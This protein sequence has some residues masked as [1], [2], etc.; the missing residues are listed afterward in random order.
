[1]PKHGHKKKARRFARVKRPTNYLVASVKGGKI[2]VVGKSPTMR[3]AKKTA[4]RHKG[5]GLA[6]IQVGAIY[7]TKESGA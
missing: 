5:R 6:I 2:R 3:G 4:L 1:M 7:G